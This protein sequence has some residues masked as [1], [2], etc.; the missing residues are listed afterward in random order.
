MHQAHTGITK[1]DSIVEVLERTSKD[2]IYRQ[3]NIVGMKQNV[4][5]AMI[6][7]IVDKEDAAER[8]DGCLDRYNRFWRTF[9]KTLI[10]NSHYS[11]IDIMHIN[12]ICGNKDD[13]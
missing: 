13:F 10:M 11:Y 2:I 3:R 6:E 9:C 4:T 5:S 1:I 8:N 12:G 7:S